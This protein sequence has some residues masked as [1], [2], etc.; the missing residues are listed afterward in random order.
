MTARLRPSALHPQLRRA[1][2]FVPNPPS[3]IKPTKPI[4]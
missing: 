3:K 1:F 2:R 4:R